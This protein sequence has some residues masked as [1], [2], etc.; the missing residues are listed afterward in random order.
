M[1][2]KKT[3]TNN[4][5]NNIQLIRTR[6]RTLFSLENEIKT[7]AHTSYGDNDDDD[8]DGGGDVEQQQLF[9]WMQAK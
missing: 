6:E 1:V 2:M 8:D 7:K 4:S 3:T 9:E 5:N